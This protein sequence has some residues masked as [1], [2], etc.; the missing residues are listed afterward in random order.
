MQLFRLPPGLPYD[1]IMGFDDSIGNR[2][3]PLHNAYGKDRPAPV[4]GDVTQAVRKVAFALPAQACDTVRWGAGENLMIEIQIAQKL[5]SVEQ[6]VCGS[7]VVADLKIAKPD[8]A[9]NI[10]GQHFGQKPVQPLARVSIQ[11]F[12]NPRF[13]P[14]L[15]GDQGIRAQAF[16]CRYGWQNSRRLPASRDKTLGKVLVRPGIFSLIEK[17]V[18]Q[19]TGATARE[20][21][22]AVDF[23]Q[24]VHVLLAGLTPG[25][26]GQKRIGRSAELNANIGKDFVRNH[27][28]RSQCTARISQCA[29]LQGKAEPVFRSAALLDV[30][31]IVVAQ[32]VVLQQR[33]IVRRQIE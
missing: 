15:G 14:T 20:R 22:V 10:A 17:P 1:P 21:L 26:I 24:R 30:V 31:Q 19:I 16:D 3:F 9:A 28:A 11:L 5:Q 7:R 13:D 33:Q 8:K 27:L 25:G 32:C 4:R 6:A 23:A 29:K 2:R 12:R 18:S